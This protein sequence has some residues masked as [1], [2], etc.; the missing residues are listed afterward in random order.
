MAGEQFGI[1]GASS[2]RGYIERTAT[3][4]VGYS[5]NVELYSPDLGKHLGSGI[6]LRALLFYDFGQINYKN[7]IANGT[8]RQVYLSSFGTGLRLNVGRDVAVK[9]DLGVA[10]NGF[11]DN[12]AT[13]AGRSRGD[14]FAHGALNVAF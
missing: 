3:G 1:G 13:D 6:N 8:E 4:D 9:F 12:P 2:V 11:P 10:H 7:P 5:G 14:L